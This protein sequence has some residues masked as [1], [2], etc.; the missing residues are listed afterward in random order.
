LEV[1]AMEEA[2]SGEA[3]MPP[4]KMS[5][6]TSLVN[7]RTSTKEV[8]KTLAKTSVEEGLARDDH[9][10]PCLLPQRRR[11]RVGEVHDYHYLRTDEA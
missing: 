3:A 8:A 7:R 1:I 6:A 9:S 10:H 2:I 11:T 5:A 4:E